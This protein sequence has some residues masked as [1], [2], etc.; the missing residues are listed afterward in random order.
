MGIAVALGALV[1]LVLQTVP[2]SGTSALARRPCPPLPKLAQPVNLDPADFSAKINNPRWPMTVG[3]RWV[4][5]VTNMET[6]HVNHDV[7]RATHRKKL[8]ADGITA[9]VVSDVVTHHGT[10]VEVTRD[11]YAQDFCGTIWYFGEH[12]IAY[13]HGKPHDNGTWQAGKHGNMPGVA[14]G[15]AQGRSDLPRGVLQ[16]PGRGPVPC[17]GSRRAGQ[18]RRWS[19]QA[20]ADDRGL[21]AHR[22][23]RVRAEVLRAR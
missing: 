23:Q 16:G 18:G 10:P 20:C 6:G 17:P 4:Y 15:R 21:L 5:R 7:I 22:A 11:W 2:S 8:I 12:T 1:A 3:S 19:L 13:R 9:R 14:P